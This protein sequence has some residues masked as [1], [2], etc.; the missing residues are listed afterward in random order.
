MSSVSSPN[1]TLHCF[2]PIRRVINQ[3]PLSTSKSCGFLSL[4][5][6]MLGYLVATPV[7]PG[8]YRQ[9]PH[10]IAVQSCRVDHCPLLPLHLSKVGQDLRLGTLQSIK[11]ET[12][13]C[14]HSN[15]DFSIQVPSACDIP[16]S[17]IIKIIFAYGVGISSPWPRPFLSIGDLPAPRAPMCAEVGK[18]WRGSEEL[19]STS[20]LHHH[21]VILQQTLSHTVVGY[22][23]GTRGKKKKKKHKHW[24]DWGAGSKQLEAPQ[25]L[26]CV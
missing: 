11:Q 26:L 16:A 8:M 13:T 20:H 9:K 18:L 3:R 5:Q 4:P 24:F 25:F 14:S 2:C 23:L 17:H 12:S 7:A 19:K 1:I 10:A 15:Y 21:H 6:V 22:L